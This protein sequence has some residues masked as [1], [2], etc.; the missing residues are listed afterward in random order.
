MRSPRQPA[1]DAGTARGRRRPRNRWLAA[2]AAA[3]VLVAGGAVAAVVAGDDEP[4]PLATVTPSETAGTEPG[5]AAA[6]GEVVLAAPPASSARC[7]V[8]TAE[9]VARMEVALDGTVAEVA[10]DRVSLDVGE[11]YAGDPG[12]GG[13]AA[14][15]VVLTNPV[16]LRAA[17]GGVPDFEV[18]QRWLVAGSRGTVAVCGFT[19]PWTPARA[20]VFEQAFPS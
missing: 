14:T 10:G 18:G 19:A 15:T 11:W 20:R 7:M 13:T 1:D 8:P 17:I 16:D 9:A 2:A 6:A 5:G 12:A 3:T 4:D